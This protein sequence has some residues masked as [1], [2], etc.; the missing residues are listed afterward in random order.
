MRRLL[1]LLFAVVLCSPAFA[2][3]P[4]NYD[5]APLRAVCAVD[6]L[7]VVAVGDHGVVWQTLDGG[8]TWD[9]MKSGSKASLRAVCFVDELQG[10]AVGRTE[11]AADTS[12][13]TV[14]KTSEHE[15]VKHISKCFPSVA[16]PQTA[17]P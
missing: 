17:A 7:H 13:G 3:L 6:R 5:D 16:A 10:W 8:K 12:V 15:C 4:P 14:L 9:R 2:F 11:R 1:A